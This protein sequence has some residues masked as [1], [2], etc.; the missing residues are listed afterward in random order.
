MMTVDGRRVYN[1]STLNAAGNYQYQ[2]NML[3]WSDNFLP[4]IETNTSWRNWASGQP[5]LPSNAQDGNWWRYDMVWA[6]LSNRIRPTST[7]KLVGGWNTADHYY[8]TSKFAMCR[9][10]SE[11]RLRGFC[12]PSWCRSL[13]AAAVLAP[14]HT[15]AQITSVW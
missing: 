5:Y 15:S 9:E 7:D 1:A 11:R 4:G 6:D 8:G 2:Q 3:V 10:K 14:C 13:C 12:F